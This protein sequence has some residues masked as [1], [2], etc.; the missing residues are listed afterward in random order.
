M[1]CSRSP[2]LD[3]KS[4]FFPFFRRLP[5]WF[6]PPFY[7]LKLLQTPFYRLGL[8]DWKSMVSPPNETIAAPPPFYSPLSS[9]LTFPPRTLPQCRKS[10]LL[11]PLFRVL[12]M[13]PPRDCMYFRLHSALFFSSNLSPLYCFFLLL[14]L[15]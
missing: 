12:V 10:L 4:F 3:D 14:R 13:G 11:I 5:F 2:L 1:F 9:P 15:L 8:P 7:G 6:L